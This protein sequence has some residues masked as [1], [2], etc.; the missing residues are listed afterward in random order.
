ML[1]PLLMSTKGKGGCGQL[2]TGP[3]SICV[4]DRPSLTARVPPDFFCRDASL[5]RAPFYHTN[6]RYK[7]N[8]YNSVFGHYKPSLSPPLLSTRQSPEAM[9]EPVPFPTTSISANVCTL[10]ASSIAAL[11]AHRRRRTDPNDNAVPTLGIIPEGAVVQHHRRHRHRSIVTIA[12]PMAARRA[13][14]KP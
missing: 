13:T 6:H 7:L 3:P 2:R 8:E 11:Y 10:N 1:A 12:N 9:H 4:E 5:S 14:R